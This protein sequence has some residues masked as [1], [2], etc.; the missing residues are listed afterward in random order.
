[1]DAKGVTWKAYNENFPGNCYAG[2]Y[3]G[4][5]FRKH[6]PFI[7]FNNVRNNATRCANIVDSSQLDLDLKNGQ[8]PQ[9]SY[10]TP[11]IDDDA[12]NTNITFAGT[13][14]DNFLAP[15]LASFPPRTLFMITW[16]EDDKT[17]GNRIDTFVWGT[18]I[19]AG[20][21]DNLPYN[22]YST[23]RTVEL[24]WDLG[25]LGRNDATANPIKF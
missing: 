4:K 22:H 8:L 19:K 1:M 12:H 23:L 11:N 21:S 18:M 16:D 15:R 13:W 25:D 9:Y 5:Y 24:N 17:E 10:F 6:N 20:A 3:L 14:L 2:Q 7:S